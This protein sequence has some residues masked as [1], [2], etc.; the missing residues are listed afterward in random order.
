MA[1]RSMRSNRI[2][3]E[4]AF[5]LAKPLKFGVAVLIVGARRCETPARRTVIA[6]AGLMLNLEAK[7]GNSDQVA[8]ERRRRLVCEAM[9]LACRKSLR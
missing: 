8:K 2:S 6:V 5:S 1:L 7:A 4:F 3:P 9:R